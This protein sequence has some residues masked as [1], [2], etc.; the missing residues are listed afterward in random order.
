[1]RLGVQHPQEGALDIRRHDG[2]TVVKADTRPQVK[3][4]TLACAVCRPAVGQAGQQPAVAIELCESVEQQSDH[5]ACGHVGGQCRV[6]RAGI[7]ALV[8]DRFPDLCPLA[9]LLA[10]GQQTQE[11]RT[12]RGVEKVD[13]AVQVSQHSQDW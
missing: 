12:L 2:A 8:V 5:L 4:V 13:S 3:D 11:Q 1:M 7:V 9:G 10:G 6:E